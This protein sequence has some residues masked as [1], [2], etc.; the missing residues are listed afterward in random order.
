MKIVCIIEDLKNWLGTLPHP[1]STT[2]INASSCTEW[3]EPTNH[4]LDFELT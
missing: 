3:Y 1:R 4:P 2:L